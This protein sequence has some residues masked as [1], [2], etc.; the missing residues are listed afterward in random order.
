MLDNYFCLM[1]VIRVSLLL[2]YFSIDII[3][4]FDLS[5]FPDEGALGKV[6][7]MH[8]PASLSHFLYIDES[9]LPSLM[10]ALVTVVDW[11]TLGV[12]L[13]VKCHTLEEIR[14]Q[15]RDHVSHC[16]LDML[17]AW[18]RSSEELCTKHQLSTA[19]WYITHSM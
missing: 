6:V 1:D 13:G 19:L 17:K 18:L 14:I 7:T 4:R 5:S 16:K 10:T 2:I 11:F 3:Q 8:L 12:Y 15:H 9:H